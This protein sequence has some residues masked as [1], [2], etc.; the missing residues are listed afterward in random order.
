MNRE[1]IRFHGGSVVLVTE[2]TRRGASALRRLDRNPFREPLPSLLSD[3]ADDRS[4]WRAHARKFLRA[5]YN[6]AKLRLGEDE[7]RDLFA[8][9]VPKRRRGRRK[10][11]AGRSGLLPNLDSVLLGAYDERVRTAKDNKE[12]ASLPRWLGENLYD[13]GRGAKFGTSDKAIQR[14]LRRLLAK[15]ERHDAESAAETQK[16]REAYRATTGQE[17]PASLIESFVADSK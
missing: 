7:A 17:L 4:R 1:D 9:A 8:E 10:G 11:E 14:H 13:K 12:R 16:L 2:K 5:W 6:Q 15:R 3:D